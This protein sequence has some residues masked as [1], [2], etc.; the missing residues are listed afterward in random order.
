MMT[1]SIRFGGPLTPMVVRIMIANAVIFLL[2]ALISLISPR[3]ADQVVANFALSH[4]GVVHQ[5]KIWQFFTYMFLHVDFFHI[6]MNLFGLW[7]FS[8]DL[9]EQ[10]GSNDFF[11]YYVISGMGAGFCIAGMNAMVYAN[12]QVNPFT[13]GA[14]GAL[15]AVLL[16][17]GITWPNREVL[18]WFVLPVKMKYVVIFFGLIEFF[19]SLN[20]AAGVGGSVSHIG[21]LGGIFT[22]FL[23]LKLMQRRGVSAK[24][25]GFIAQLLY[26]RKLART[27]RRI[28]RRN[29][30]KR[31]IDELLDKIARHGMS[32]LTAEEKKKLE[33]ARRNYFPDRDET[34]H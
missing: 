11:K 6:F 18:L 2:M 3:F 15:Y 10:W 19:G 12:Y 27:R 24:K 21:H 33:W 7:M 13:M 28:E 8:G 29:E 25:R 31:I 5:L 22:G 1:R 26:K 34:I 9:E 30:A 17:Y 20:M 14:S 4:V 32:S 23:Y 16:A